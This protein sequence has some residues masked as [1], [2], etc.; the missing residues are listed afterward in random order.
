MVYQVL[1][2]DEGRGDIRDLLV[3]VEGLEQKEIRV[4][5]VR[6]VCPG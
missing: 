6:L 4:A 2:A 1:K 5:E 3:R